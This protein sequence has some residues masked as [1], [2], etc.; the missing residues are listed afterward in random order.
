MTSYLESEL[1]KYEERKYSNFYDQKIELYCEN[2]AG[3]SRDINSKRRI[4]K[5]HWSEAHLSLYGCSKR[6]ASN[7]CLVTFIIE[8]G[9]ADPFDSQIFSMNAGLNEEKM[10]TQ[11]L[12]G[13]KGRR[14]R[15]NRAR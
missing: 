13:S 1:I 7:I 15:G 8:I 12:I 10:I 6:H 3:E 5:R 14:K 2:V 11:F 9:F 4:Q